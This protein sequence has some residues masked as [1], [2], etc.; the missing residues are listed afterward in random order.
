[1]NQPLKASSPQHHAIGGPLP[2]LLDFR[3]GGRGW[4][5]SL[6]ALVQATLLGLVLV[7]PL[8]FIDPVDVPAREWISPPI[9]KGDPHGNPNVKEPGGRQPGR[10]TP[11]TDLAS[12][13]V[14]FPNTN[15]TVPDGPVVP[16]GDG[17]G[18]GVGPGR[19]GDPNGPDIGMPPLPD[20]VP[21]PRA[22]DPPKPK[23]PVRVGGVVRPPRLIHRV[24]PAYPPLALRTRI[25]GEVVMEAVLGE[26]G[27]VREITVKSGHPQL[28]PA[29]R[30]AVAQWVYEPTLLNGEPY[31][32]VL[33]VRI[34]FFLNP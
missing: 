24:E 2:V 34:R 14:I 1:M 10:K 15:P 7:L 21:P 31:P 22:A 11:K 12:I 5:M 29:A 30:D 25:Q 32:V 4:R 26:D 17:S 28:V 18:P 16:N 19:R 13:Q 27:R 9:W 8:L 33:E 3:N 20:V 23:D 6:G